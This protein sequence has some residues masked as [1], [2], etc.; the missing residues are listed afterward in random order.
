[1]MNNF[2]ASRTEELQMQIKHGIQD[3]INKIMFDMQGKHIKAVMDV[4][5]TEAENQRH[6]DI[7]AKM[8]EQLTS[9]HQA[10]A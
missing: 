8:D 1:M 9:L 5:N 3:E 2:C 7:T 10:A 4:Q 6:R